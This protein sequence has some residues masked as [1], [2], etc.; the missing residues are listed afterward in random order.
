[1]D[2]D[3]DEDNPLQT[4]NFKEQSGSRWVPKDKLLP[5]FTGQLIITAK[6]NTGENEHDGN[7]TFDVDYATVTYNPEGLTAGIDDENITVE[8]MVVDAN[9]EPMP[10]GTDLYLWLENDTGDFEFAAGDDQIELDEG[11]LGEFEVRCTGDLKTWVNA[12]LGDIEWGEEWWE[13]G[14]LTAGNLTIDW[15]NFA[16]DPDTIFIGQ[17]NAITITATD[18]KGDPVLHMNLTLYM[19]SASWSYPTPVET[20]EN[21][22]VTFS[23]APDA[24][25]KAN[26][27]IVRGIT[28]VNGM[29]EWD[30]EDSIVTDTYVT[31][32]A[33]RTM[34]IGV[35]KSPVAQGDTLTVTVTSNEAP[36]ADANVEF[37]GTTVKT[38]AAGQ[39][40]FT[41]PDP[42]VD[43]A[44]YTIK[45]EKT[46]YVTE[47]R[48]I[49]V[50]K[51]YVITAI[52]PGTAPKA[53]ETFTITL[54]AKGMPLAGATI[55]FNGKT[56]TSD[57]EGKATI[58]APSTAGD[59]PLTASYGTYKDYE[60]TIT[61]LEGGGIPGF[62]LVT[63]VIAIGIAFILL[64]RRR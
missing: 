1:V 40:T 42:G 10:E 51:I 57:G 20:D 5:W 18:Y 24:S 54:I 60:T 13:Q 12:T 30:E 39:A 55:T 22:V 32:T 61:V 17:A 23:I 49:T 7:I 37:A 25:G 56:V 6:N 38:N 35:S 9:G 53:G 33:V 46:G 14:N 34:S 41:A 45:A 58:T 59:Y 50:I 48:D 62:E 47:Y 52:M 15:P 19:G 63:L 16:V 26:V 3:H 2:E 43:F 28:W 27:T 31:V 36:I 4:I 21:G 64:R 29:M 8:I 11:G 44:S